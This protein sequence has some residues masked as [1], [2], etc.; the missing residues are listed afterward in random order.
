MGVLLSGSGISK[1]I[2]KQ[3]ILDHINIELYEN[4]FTVIMG[5]SGAGKSSLLYA[6]S[7]MDKITE[8]SIAYRGQDIRRL[9]EKQMAHLRAAEFGFIFQ[10]MH[11]VSNLTLYENVFVAGCLSSKKEKELKNRV[12]ELLSQMN[13]GSAMN[14]LPCHVSGGEAQ[15]AAIARAVINQPGI[16]FAYEPT[17]ALN[18]QNT[19]EVMALIARLNSAGQSIVMVTHDTRT[20]LYGNRLLYMEDGKLTGELKLPKFEEASE[21]ERE[22]QI[23]AWLSSMDW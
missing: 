22:S 16:V 9:N 19:T 17:G 1:T 20:A 6:L 4:D 18:K 23:T 7:G 8:G 14:R 11:L 13:V 21:K 5:A 2:G 10:G 12:L 3:K 15:R